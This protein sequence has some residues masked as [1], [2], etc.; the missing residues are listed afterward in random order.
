MR[1]TASGFRWSSQS[2]PSSAG[3]SAIS[4]CTSRSGGLRRRSR[5]RGANDGRASADGFSSLSSLAG[6]CTCVFC[7]GATSTWFC[8]PCGSASRCTKCC[9]SEASDLAVPPASGGFFSCSATGFRR[10]N[11]GQ[12]RAAKGGLATAF[13]VSSGPAFGSRGD[14]GASLVRKAF[15]RTG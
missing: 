6:K 2:R 11:A 13:T 15:L 7:S 5:T 10:A 8:A 12:S 9:S 4:T 1:T 14:S 3:R